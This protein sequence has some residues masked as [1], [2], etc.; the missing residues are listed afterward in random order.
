[1][2]QAAIDLGDRGRAGG[3]PRSSFGPDRTARPDPPAAPR[4]A[5]ALM[6]K[7]KI[8]RGPARPGA[9]GAFLTG[10]IRDSA[11][12]GPLR[13]GASGAAARPMARTEV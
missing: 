10:Y 9:G 1:M 7:A 13:Q 8:N 4:V 6:S 11:K 2:P 5:A 12:A 3:Q